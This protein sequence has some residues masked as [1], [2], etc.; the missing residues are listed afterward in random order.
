VEK[1][2][3][4]IEIPRQ[5]TYAAKWSNIYDAENPDILHLTDQYFGDNR[6]LPLWVA[7]MDFPAPQPV[8]DALVSRAKHGIYGYTIRDEHYDQAVVSWMQRRHN[9]PVNPQW[10]SITPGVVTA[11]NNLVQ[12]FVKPGDKVLIQPPVYHP[13]YSTIK[14][15]K[16]KIAANPL[17]YENGRYFMDFDD[18]HNKVADPQV[19]MAILCSPHNP[20]GRVWTAEELTRFGEICLANGVLVVSDEIHADLTFLGSVFTPFAG[21]N[22]AFAQNCVVCTAPS[23]TFNL[24]GLKTS[25]IIIPDPEKR[26]AFQKQLTANGIHGLNPFGAEALKAAYNKGEPWLTQVLVYIE[27]NF[28][29]LDDFIARNIPQ[30]KVVPLQGTYLVWLDCLELGL[31]PKA[32]RKLF[33]DDA[34]V[35]LDDGYIFGPEG[36]GFQRV[37]IACPRPILVE[38]LDR[39]QRTIAAQQSQPSL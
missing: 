11:L 35:C 32:L 3:L 15:N 26:E 8:I 29:Y 2:N 4:D 20:V 6:T 13:F 28:R 18:L 30:I 12:A 38:A 22:N 10:L 7:D 27:E 16:A 37:N 33:L 31:S 5:N 25:N 23:K 21:I 39:I 17:L 19:T 34:K 1:Y 24:A 14:N 9:W 36:A